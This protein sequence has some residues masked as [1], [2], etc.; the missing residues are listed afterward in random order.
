MKLYHDKCESDSQSH[1]DCINWCIY[2][3]K[4]KTTIATILANYNFKD[5]IGKLHVNFNVIDL[6]SLWIYK[7][8]YA[9]NS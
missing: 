1:T 8:M 5:Y 3:K 2:K 7:Y 4:K 6:E 9:Y